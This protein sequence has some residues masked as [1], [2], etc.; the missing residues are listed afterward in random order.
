MD[1]LT[2][3]L[4]AREFV[5][6]VSP[7]K[8]PVPMDAYARYAEATIK[9][10]E[11][12]ADDEDGF[13][14]MKPNGKY[15]ICVNGK[16]HK[17][18]QR[19][20][21]CHELAHILLGLPSEHCSGPSW[22][23]VKRSRN[24]I[25]C[26]VFAAEL[27]LPY[28]LFK[29]LV[30]DVD[31][32]LAAVSELASRFEASLLATGSRFATLANVPAAFVLSEAGKVRYASRST[33]LRAANGWIPISVPIPEGSVAHR[34]RQGEKGAGPEEIE[35]DTWFDD[36]DRD[37]TLLEDAQHLTAYDQTISLLWFEEDELTQRGQGAREREVET[38]GLAELN[39]ILPWPGRSKRR[40]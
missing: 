22:S 6:K 10:L 2:V 9:V 36:W 8:I 13:S 11:D 19:F 32:S 18:R 34:R 14:A 35:P 3:V 37:G 7:A 27:L 29:P 24:E 1:E 5:N 25:L 12:L 28:K 30:E 16:Q 21:I 17:E 26:D 38:S 4:K 33:T 31:C 15:G 39:G 23:Y 40:R 20:T